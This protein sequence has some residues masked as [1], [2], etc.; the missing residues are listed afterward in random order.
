MGSPA[1]LNA[2]KPPNAFRPLRRTLPGCDAPCLTSVVI[3]LMTVSFTQHADYVPETNESLSV[4]L[5]AGL[6]A[7]AKKCEFHKDRMES[8]GAEVS[9][10]GFEM[11]QVKVETVRN[12]SGTRIHRILQLLQSIYSEVARPPHDLTKKGQLWQWNDREEHAF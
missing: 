9:P 4:D 11:E 12:K 1:S 5:N 8:L 10:E 3:S 6:F 2:P 7:N